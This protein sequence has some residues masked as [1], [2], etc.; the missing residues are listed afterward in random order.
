[1]TTIIKNA[2]TNEH[3]DYLLTIIS[4]I[5]NVISVTISNI[6]DLQLVQISSRNF[7]FEEIPLLYSTVFRKNGED[8]TIE[9]IHPFE[10]L[11]KLTL[12]NNASVINRLTNLLE[13][14][15]DFKDTYYREP[16][17]MSPDGIVCESLSGGY[18]LEPIPEEEIDQNLMNLIDFIKNDSPR[19]IGF[20]AHLIVDQTVIFEPDSIA[21]KANIAAPE[22]R[23]PGTA[24]YYGASRTV[25]PSEF[26]DTTKYSAISEYF[27]D[28]INTKFNVN[29][30]FTI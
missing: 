23:D 18:I 21:I 8:R 9:F 14:M 12:P 16:R 15:F 24:E 4:Q 13:R 11:I 3:V 20:T 6:T 29:S 1:M 26:N 19:I 10:Y 5:P 30:Q 7:S 28:I 22:P 2:A 27:Q 17:Y 25:S